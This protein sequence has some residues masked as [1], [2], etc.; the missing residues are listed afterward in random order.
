MNQSPCSPHSPI[1]HECAK[2]SFPFTGEGVSS[3]AQ[4]VFLATRVW[5]KAGVR[6]DQ[7]ISI[8]TGAREREREREGGGRVSVCA[9][10]FTSIGN[11]YYLSFFPSMC[12]HGPFCLQTK[13]YL[14]A[15]YFA[16]PFVIITKTIPPE[17]SLCNVAASGVSLF[18]RKHKQEICLAK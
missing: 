10:A 2:D 15:I 8:A 11:H 1:L 5:L 12:H 9:C 14:E 13:L 3:L 18:A 16:I 7:P 6:K 17:D 4:I